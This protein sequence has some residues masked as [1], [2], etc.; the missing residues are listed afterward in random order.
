MEET[1]VRLAEELS[2]V[3]RDYCNISWDKAL[4]VVGIPADSK[5]RRKENIYYDPEIRATPK[6][7]PSSTAPASKQPLTIQ[8]ALPLSEAPKESN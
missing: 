5:W 8:A 3:C 6:A 1:Q 4:D 2:E 7:L